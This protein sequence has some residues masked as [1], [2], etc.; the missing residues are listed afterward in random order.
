M[1][2]GMSFWKVEIKTDMTSHRGARLTEIPVS[3]RGISSLRS[4]KVSALIFLPFWGLESTFSLVDLFFKQVLGGLL[5][6]N[7]Q[8]ANPRRART[9]DAIQQSSAD[10]QS[11]DNRKKFKIT[12]LGK[13]VI[14]GI[15]GGRDSNLWAPDRGR[16]GI[17]LWQ[18]GRGVLVKTSEKKV[19]QTAH[20][21]KYH[22]TGHQL[23]F[24]QT[25]GR[26]QS[27][28]WVSWNRKPELSLVWWWQ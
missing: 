2:S 9:V 17:W 16:V 26:G 20:C 28:S 11:Y 23:L 27:I 25:K 18:L 24:L 1:L 4:R 10:L 8:T 15:H 21:D 13:K 7:N 19:S 6:N 22:S 12:L 3:R 14:L 5:G